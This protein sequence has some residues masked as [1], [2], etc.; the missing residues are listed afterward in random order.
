MRTGEKLLE[1]SL[2][3]PSG[4]LTAYLLATVIALMGILLRFSIDPYVEGVLFIAY[5]PAVLIASLLCGTGPGILAAVICGLASW[6]IFTPPRL[7]WHMHSTNQLRA[8]V[9]YFLVAPLGAAA[10]GAL[11][12]AL[13][14]LRDAERRQQLLI[15]ELQHRSRNLLA[16]VSSTAQQTLRSSSTL[17]AFGRRFRGRL[18]ALGRVQ[19]LLSRGDEQIELGELIRTE[20][21]AHNAKLKDGLVHVSGPPLMLDPDAVQTVALAIHE[22]AT[23]AVKYGA[24]AQPQARLDVEWTLE[25]GEQPPRAFIRWIESGVE[26]QQRSNSPSTGFGRQLI[27]KALPYDLG[28]RTSFDLTSDGVHCRINLP[29][30]KAAR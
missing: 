13:K 15:A 30:G 23:N 8:L 28:A 6:Y 16:V 24:L 1:Q 27:E 5:F 9:L 25:Q 29:L 14:K 7:S 26:M 20:L 21:A 19:G 4:S 22:L 18:A 12:N 2:S 3:A 10:V 11:R 17:E